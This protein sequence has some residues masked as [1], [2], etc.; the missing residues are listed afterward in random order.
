MKDK[1]GKKNSRDFGNN[2]DDNMFGQPGKN[3]SL[4][5]LQANVAKTSSR[6]GHGLGGADISPS[7]EMGGVG[8]TI[9]GLSPRDS[10]GR[11]FGGT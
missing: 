3:P 4:P 1:K 10:Q 9:S 11:S 8:A 6:A 7:R 5:G 2:L